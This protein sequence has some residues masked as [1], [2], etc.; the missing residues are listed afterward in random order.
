MAGLQAVGAAPGGGGAVPAVGVRGVRLL[1]TGAAHDGG[2]S[3]R[4]A[5]TG[6]GGGGEQQNNERRYEENG[7][8]HVFGK[9]HDEPEGE[10]IFKQNRTGT[11]G[12]YRT[13]LRGAGAGKRRGRR[14][15]GRKQGDGHSR[16][17]RDSVFHREDFFFVEGGSG[18][19][20]EGEASAVWAKVAAVRQPANETVVL[21]QPRHEGA[22]EGGRQIHQESETGGP[23]GGR[24]GP[25]HGREG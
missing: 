5:K 12:T 17:V 18:D 19:R 9:R 24:S 20:E 13:Q 8:G 3:Q 21:A 22:G 10:K 6:E 16:R 23:V 1:G 11:R 2:D 14:L 7:G 4:A 25:I 15:E